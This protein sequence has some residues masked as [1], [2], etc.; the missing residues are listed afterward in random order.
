MQLC[1]FMVAAT[2]MT[3]LCPGPDTPGQ[4]QPPLTEEDMP[5]TQRCFFGILQCP[6]E[7]D[8]HVLELTWTS[9]W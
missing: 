7:S 3:L 6:Q 8:S 5:G 4:Q 1:P 9:P 2:L